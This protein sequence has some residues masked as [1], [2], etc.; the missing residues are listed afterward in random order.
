M[1]ILKTNQ[2]SEK[3]ESMM[4]FVKK[5]EHKLVEFHNSHESKHVMPYMYMANASWLTAYGEDESIM[6]VNNIDTNP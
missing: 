2:T 4:N 6:C 1:N 5:G 3:K